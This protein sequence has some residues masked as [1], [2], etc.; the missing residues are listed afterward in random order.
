MAGNQDTNG[1]DKGTE[2][3]GKAGKRGRGGMLT[4]SLLVV[5]AA[6]IG[7]GFMMFSG[8]GSSEAVGMSASIEAPA[9]EVTYEEV[10][11]FDGHTRGEQVCA[12]RPV[13]QDLIELVLL[14]GLGLIGLI[15][16]EFLQSLVALGLGRA[17]CCALTIAVLVECGPDSAHFFGIEAVLEGDVHSQPRCGQPLCH[18]LDGILVIGSRLLE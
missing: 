15:P 13:E 2:P 4:L 10:V 14:D 1:N 9:Y 6:A 17:P 7:A 5:E 12:G 11:I 18:G 16:S 8:S 3:T